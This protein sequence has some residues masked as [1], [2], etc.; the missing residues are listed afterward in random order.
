MSHFVIG[1]SELEAE[2][3]EKIFSLEIDLALQS[4]A[5]V[6]RMCEGSSFDN[7][8]NARSENKTQI[9]KRRSTEMKEFYRP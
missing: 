8:V 6:G 3:G 9:L 4:I 5:E 2:Y 7:I 1:P